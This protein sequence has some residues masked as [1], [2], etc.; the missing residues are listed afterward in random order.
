[1]EERGLEVPREREV[2]LVVQWADPVPRRD[3]LRDVREPAT[4]DVELEALREQGR[5]LVAGD[6]ADAR[7]EHGHEPARA[8]KARITSS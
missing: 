1:M 6:S 7:A 4:V 8:E 3:G 5:Q 2:E